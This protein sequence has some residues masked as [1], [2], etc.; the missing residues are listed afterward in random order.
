LEAMR[1]R[2]AQVSLRWIVSAVVVVA[3]VGLGGLIALRIARPTVTVTE[4]VTGPVVQAFYSTGTIQPEREF[5]IKSNTAGILQQVLVDKGDHVKKGQALAVVS[6]PALLYTKDKAQAEL[7]EKL[8]RA[9][10]KTSPVLGEFDSKIIA[11]NDMLAIAKR[12]EQRLR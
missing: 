2:R 3:V 6:D 12:E 5:P 11:A 10:D 4:A 1:Q 8:K 9:D 7:D